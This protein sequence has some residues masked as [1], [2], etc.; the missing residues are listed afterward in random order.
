[1]ESDLVFLDQDLFQIDSVAFARQASEI[2]ATG[3]A[4][5]RGPEMLRLYRGGFAPE[6]EYEEWSEDW[7]THLHGA[8]LRLAH[9]TSDGLVQEGRFADAA[10]VLAPVVA[11]DPTA[12]ELRAT[13]VAC[14]AAIGA[15][16]AAQAHYRSM[17]AAHERDLGLPADPF[18]EIVKRLRPM[19]D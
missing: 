9:A 19:S 2:L 18:A 16:D 12:F 4:T 11:L 7:R 5:R 6:F 15:L 17:A 10:E 1:M 3:T 8:F 13:M 14:L